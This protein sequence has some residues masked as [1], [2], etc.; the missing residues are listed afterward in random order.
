MTLLI[1]LCVLHMY[2]S[3]AEKTG[4]TDFGEKPKSIYG[5]PFGKVAIPK[6]LT[7]SSV[8]HFGR[9]GHIYIYI[10]TL[11]IY[12][13]YIIERHQNV[14]YCARQKH[15]RN[16]P[17]DSDGRL[18][19]PPQ[20][21]DSVK[22]SFVSV[23]NTSSHSL[24]TLPTPRTPQEQPLVTPSE[25][26]GACGETERRAVQVQHASPDSVATL[27][28]LCP[29]AG[30]AE[31]QHCLHTSKGDLERA[32]CL[33]LYRQETGTAITEKTASTSRKVHNIC[34]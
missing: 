23:G 14:L 28:E 24:P 34:I 18:S 21:Q 30:P 25:E 26:A 20:E 31:L 8:T 7:S 29:A 13:M 22:D 27:R 17:V 16:L 1:F 33:L 19:L 3:D 12:I 15:L 4:E 6:R 9:E 2:F 32:A 11:Y 10:Y 5:S